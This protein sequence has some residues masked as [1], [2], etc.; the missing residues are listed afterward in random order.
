MEDWADTDPLQTEGFAVAHH[1]RKSPRQRMYSSR[2]GMC[3]SAACCIAIGC[4]VAGFDKRVRGDNEYVFLVPATTEGQQDA[5]RRHAYAADRA[6]S[7]HQPL[8][9]G[10][11]Q[12]RRIVLQGVGLPAANS[13]SFGRSAASAAAGLHATQILHVQIQALQRPAYRPPARRRKQAVSECP[14]ASYGGRLDA[15]TPS[16][17]R[18]TRNR[19]TL[20]DLVRSHRPRPEVPSKCVIWRSS[21]TSSHRSSSRP[22]ACVMA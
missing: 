3:A 10:R 11:H 12:H 5:A 7:C 20:T 19:W 15:G 16:Q 22:L 14:V 2:R 18:T 1:V 9:R 6:R 21:S 13:L 17:A 4:C 8:A